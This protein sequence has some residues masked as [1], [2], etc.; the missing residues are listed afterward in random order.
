MKDRGIC[1][2]RVRVDV[3]RVSRFRCEL[4]EKLREQTL[5]ARVV[6][7]AV[8]RVV[9]GVVKAWCNAWWQW[10]S[11]C[12]WM[13][14]RRSDRRKNPVFLS[15]GMVRERSLSIAT[16]VQPLR[17]ILLAH[18]FA[19]GTYS[20]ASTNLSLRLHDSCCRLHR[21]LK[22]VRLSSRH[23]NV[24]DAEILKSERSGT[25]FELLRLST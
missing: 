22:R 21:K 16:V 9:Q 11:A 1:A 25:D 10:M 14:N 2:V 12:V 15:L 3:S 20:S 7:G 24:R 19:V 4:R 5:R 23:A 13:R 6:K 8:R 17:S 18:I